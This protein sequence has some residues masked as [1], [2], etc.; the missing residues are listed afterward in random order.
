MIKK[1]ATPVGRRLRDETIP[2]WF[3]QKPP[4]NLNKHDSHVSL[5]SLVWV[6]ACDGFTVYQTR[7]GT[8]IV[9]CGPTAGRRLWREDV[10]SR[11][12]A[13]RL[14][15]LKLRE[16]VRLRSS[17]LLSSVL[18]LFCNHSNFSVE[19]RCSY[20]ATVSQLTSS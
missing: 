20:Q 10:V 1:N 9:S 13:L 5:G 12:G 4:S 15:R 8:R 11:D 16:C 6:T 14:Q 7:S 19:A 3:C 2:A 18:W 17:G